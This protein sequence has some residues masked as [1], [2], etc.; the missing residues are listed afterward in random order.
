MENEERGYWRNESYRAYIPRI[1]LSHDLTIGEAGYEQCD[2]LHRWGPGSRN[3]W[4]FHCVESGK[5]LLSIN[6]RNYE[7]GAGDFFVMGPEDY[8]CYVADREQPWAYRWISFNGEK[9]ADIM[10]HVS[11]GPSAPVVRLPDGEGA[12]IIESI[13]AG[14]SGTDFPQFYALGRLYMFVEWLL[15]SFPKASAALPDRAREYFFSIINYIEVQ[16][17]SEMNVQRISR[18]LGFDRTYIFKLFKRFIGVSPSFYIECLKTYTACRLLEQN[19]YSLR[20]AASRSG[21]SDYSWFCKVFK[22]CAGVSPNE[23]VR[24][25]NKAAVLNGY[26]LTIPRNALADLERFSKNAWQG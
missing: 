10:A 8:V 1:I 4:T 15:K 11:V 14:V 24:T 2:P 21:F 5:G 3:F 25:D 7:V 23:Y 9:A 26:N 12:A 19:K 20:E 13:Y 6:G 17:C 18:E 22:K 16:G